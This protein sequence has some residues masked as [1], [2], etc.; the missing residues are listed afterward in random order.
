LGSTE[1]RVFIGQLNK[2]Q[3]FKESPPGS[4]TFPNIIRGTNLQIFNPFPHFPNISQTG[5][6]R[7]TPHSPKKLVQRYNSRTAFGGKGKVV[8][9]LFLN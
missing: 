6:S 3:H 1:G 9:V 4:V 7:V 5:Y 8:P 2:Y